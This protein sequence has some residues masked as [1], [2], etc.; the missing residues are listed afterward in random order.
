MIVFLNS[1]VIDTVTEVSTNLCVDCEQSLFSFSFSKGNA[2]ARE[3]WPEKPRDA[4]N[5]GVS[6]RAFSQARGHLRVSG[7]LLDGPRKKRDCSQSNLCG[8]ESSSE[9]KWVN[10]YLPKKYLGHSSLSN[11]SDN[12]YISFLSP[13]KTHKFAWIINKNTSK[14]VGNNIGWP[15]VI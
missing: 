3:R 7:V 2:R 5:E 6:S 4:R 14:Q 12:F 1:T 10:N 8:S 11:D 15:I 13:L 9:L